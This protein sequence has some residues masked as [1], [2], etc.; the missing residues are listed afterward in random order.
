MDNLQVYADLYFSNGINAPYHLKEGGDIEIK[1]VLLKDYPYYNNAVG[2]LTLPK[3]EVNDIEII[4]MSYLEYLIKVV[5]PSNKD[6][7]MLMRYLLDLCLGAE[8]VAFMIK[9]NKP[10]IVICDK[11]QV[12]KHIINSR[13][14]DDISEI[15]LNQNDAHYDNRTVNPEV[16]QLMEDYYRI[17]YKDVSV[18]SLEKRKAFVSSKIGKTFKELGEY[19]CREFEEIY[20]AMLDSE[21]YMATKIT[22]ASY[23]YEVKEQTKHPQYEPEKDRFE[24]IFSDTSV[25][26]DKGFKGADNI[27][28]QF[29][30]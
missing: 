2:I 26:K 22:E 10:I 18:P 8:Y 16:R 30:D 9:N 17:K 23:K 12:V 29:D 4:R 15:I 6:Y 13:E 25:L 1:P 19:T 14:F 28:Q 21:I 20:R 24:E 11:E 5:F 27:G 3:N 7:E